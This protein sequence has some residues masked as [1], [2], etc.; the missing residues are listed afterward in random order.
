MSIDQS[1]AINTR[2]DFIEFVHALV[3]ELD[4]DPTSW[5]NNTLSTFLESL[6]AWLG[7]ADGYYAAL[8][9][10]VPNQPTWEL[11]AQSLLAARS[12]E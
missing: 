5:E 9:R 4:R 8:S 10:T 11:F 6:A 1:G 12:Y 2:A 7:D 3:Q